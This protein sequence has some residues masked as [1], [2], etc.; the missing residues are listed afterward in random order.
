MQKFPPWLRYVAF[1]GM[2]LLII[3]GAIFWIANNQR[4]VATII[5][6]LF[7]A[8]G[9]IF[10]FIQIF[11]ASKTKPS[12][13]MHEASPTGQAV[14]SSTE[15]L[16][17][18]TTLPSPAPVTH[19]LPE[20]NSALLIPENALLVQDMEQHNFHREDW[21]EAPD[22]RHFYGRKHELDILRHLVLDESCRL[23]TL[24]G[25]G[26]SGKTTLATQFAEQVKD[27]FTLVFWR[28]LYNTPSLEELLGSCL[29][30]FTGS[31]TE[32]IPSTVEEQLRLLLDCFRRS[33]CLLLLDNFESVLQEGSSA[34]QYRS[35]YEAYRRLLQR[36]GEAHH[37]SCLLITT[38]E[39]P[40]DIARLEG[41]IAA[42]RSLEITG[43]DT[44]GGRELLQESHL[45]GDDAAWTT[46][47]ARY[48][49]N[50]LALNLAA[51][52]IRIVFNGDI[53][54][55]LQ[56]DESIFGDIRAL[57]DEQF[58]RLPPLE[59]EI[60]FWLAIER[61]P[62]M[63]ENLQEDIIH[64]V[65]KGA[66]LEALASL[67]RR[68][69][70]EVSGGIRFSLQAVVMEYAL[71]TLVE[72][73]YEEV[74]TTQLRAF[75]HIA[76]M[77]ASSS[78]DIRT[79]QIRLLLTPLTQRLLALW[80]KVGMEQ[81][82]A[83]LL[84]VI[85]ATPAYVHSYA[86]GNVLNLLVAAQGYIR[87]MNFAHVTVRQAYVQNVQL[88]DVSFAYAHILSSAFTDTFGGILSIAFRASGDAF[89]VGTANGEIRIWQAATGKLL[90]LCQ[91]HTDAVWSVAFS[92]DGT[93]LASGSQDQTIRLWDCESGQCLHVLQEQSTRIWSVAFSPDG[94]RLVSGG[95]DQQVHIWDSNTGETVS[96]LAGHTHR[97]RTVAWS[98]TGTLLASGSA[99]KTIRL[100]DS[101]T[102]RCLHVLEGH[103]EGIRAVQFQADGTLLASAGGD[104][105]VRLWNAETAQCLNTLTG[106]TDSVRTLSFSSDGTLLASAG[107]DQSVRLWNMETAQCVHTMRYHT[108]RV[109]AVAFR[110]DSTMLA[111]GGDD[112]TVRLWDSHSEHTIYT[113]YGYT[114]WIWSLAM[115]PYGHMLASSDQAIHLWNIQARQTPRQ[116]HT[117]SGHT[118]RIRTLAFSP[119]GQLLA[120]GSEDQT[121]RLWDMHSGETLHVLKGHTSWIRSVAFHPEKPLLASGSDDQSVRLWDCD[122]GQ[123]VR[124][125]S[126][127][128]REIRAVVFHP[129]GHLLATAGLD[130]M[131][132][133]WDVMTGKIVCTLSGHTNRIRA[134]AFHPE[135]NVLASGGA[136]QTIRLWDSDTG[137]CVHILQEKR[138]SIRSLAFSP[139]GRLLASSGDDRAI[140]LWNTEQLQVERLLSGHESRIR[141]LAFFLDGSQ[142]ASGSDDGTIKLWNVQNGLC[143]DTLR[144]DRPY[145]RMDIT[146]ATGL[147][148]V[149][150]TSLLALG[151][152]D[153]SLRL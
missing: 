131:I 115:H 103:T 73:M 75:A 135:G 86:A 59:Q 79:A 85:R 123:C 36:V 22:V 120:S 7:V 83:Q 44:A 78:D 84:D 125:L 104:Q 33:R 66:L 30:F 92:P 14:P 145:E 71:D 118:N 111:S 117:L 112:R 3:V 107:D 62:I 58:H 82:F 124:I 23:I 114:T 37:Q 150:H 13:P 31:S 1:L 21:G 77:K 55:F 45:S 67:R 11:P 47:V 10:S 144:G 127:Q 89:A 39:K 29:R 26:G 139:N 81:K 2:L 16:S 46:L 149:Q 94:T 130:N 136:D 91:G 50:P 153:E 15:V 20:E 134:L 40:R 4:P 74:Q 96:M 146:G 65:P 41:T 48:S 17:A 148:K 24:S 109:W 19:K 143:I 108:N 132:Y 121:A 54:R 52:T 126:G 88:N 6:I 99:D 101:Q 18:Q 8:L 35:G 53:A 5:S 87:H 102:G 12:H 63:L 138:A 140:S 60:L 152:I 113:L 72:Q 93:R 129:R 49:G 61:S 90:L 105:S 97:V 142:L 32:Q 100:W 95:D 133:L 116:A 42:V 69:M 151:A 9:L 56:E 147:S 51:E 64:P 76:L 38:R 98:P 80:G 106:H 43:V 137:Q 28:S 110:P 141:S 128:R 25:I 122:T 70:I 27:D 68:S 119:N 34:G 57:F